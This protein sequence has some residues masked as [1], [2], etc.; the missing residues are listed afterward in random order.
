MLEV[1]DVLIMSCVILTQ[2]GTAKFN[3]NL[4]G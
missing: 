2:N 3:N 4:N 1:L